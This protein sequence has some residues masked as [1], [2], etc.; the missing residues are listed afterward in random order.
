MHQDVAFDEQ[1]YKTIWNHL[2]LFQF[3]RIG[4]LYNQMKRPIESHQ[5][6]MKAGRFDKAIDVLLESKRFTEAIKCIQDY[7]NLSEV[8]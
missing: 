1:I 2:G 6:Y 8:C 5:F 4:N 7:Q 3:E